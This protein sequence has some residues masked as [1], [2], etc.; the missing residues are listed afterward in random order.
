MSLARTSVGG[1][2]V[3]FLNKVLYYPYSD[4][5]LHHM[6]PGLADVVIKARQERIS[7]DR[8]LWGH[9]EASILSAR[10]TRV[11]PVQAIE[12]HSSNG[13]QTEDCRAQKENQPPKLKLQLGGRYRDR[14]FRML[15]PAQV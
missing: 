14:D 8:P 3:F 2:E 15:N 1:I 13:T 5:A 6:G 7:S 11:R 10:R 9:R 4:F 12:G